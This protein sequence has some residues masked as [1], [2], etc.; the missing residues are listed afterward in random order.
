MDFL[1][2]I[3]F[4]FIVLYF[5]YVIKANFFFLIFMLAVFLF[6]LVHLL[7]LDPIQNIDVIIDEII[8]KPWGLIILIIFTFFMIVIRRLKKKVKMSKSHHP[9]N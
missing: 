1:Y 3:F 9:Q 6:F 5:A 4:L 7:I 8:L 2:A